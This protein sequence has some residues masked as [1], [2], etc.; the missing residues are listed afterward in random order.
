VNVRLKGEA[1]T[2]DALAAIAGSL[3]A[4]GVIL[5]VVYLAIQV[6]KNTLATHSQTYYLATAALAEMAALIASNRELTHVYRIGM[7]TP[8]QSSEDE[9]LQFALI[10]VSQFRRYEN[11]FYQ[12]RAGL[13]DEDFWIAHRE[14]ILWFFHR[15]GMQMWWKEKRLAYSKGFREFLESSKPTDLASP[16]NRRV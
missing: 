8:D 16:T 9:S 5:T 14:N 13:V 11:L 1:M 10:G 4:I 15:P 2:W 6:R 7:S 12:Y 3:G